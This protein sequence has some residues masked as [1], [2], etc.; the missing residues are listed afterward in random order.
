MDGAPL[1]GAFLIVRTGG[2]VDFAWL[3]ATTGKDG[4]YRL[5]AIPAGSCHVAVQVTR[6][7][8]FVVEVEAATLAPGENRIDVH[9]GEGDRTAE[10]AGRAYSKTT[11][12]PASGRALPEIRLSTLVESAPG[13]WTVGPDA[14]VAY[15]DKEGAFRLPGLRAARYWVRSIHS[16][17]TEPEFEVDLR[18]GEKRTDLEIALPD[19]PPREASKPSVSYLVGTLTDSDGR[20]MSGATVHATAATPGRGSSGS[21]TDGSGRFRIARLDPGPYRLRIQFSGVDGFTSEVAD[22]TVVAGTNS[23]DLH[24]DDAATAVLSGRV[25]ARSSGKSLGHP[26]VRLGLRLLLADG[27]DRDVGMALPTS[28]G[29]FTIRYV[30]PGRLRLVAD[31]RAPGLAQR[32]IELEVTAGARM[33][34]LEVALDDAATGTVVLVVKDG[35]GRPVQ[36]V[37]IVCSRDGGSE[38]APIGGVSA[39]GV[40][41]IY[42]EPGA[43]DVML[44]TRDSID[45][46]TVE[47]RP[48]ETTRAEFTM[49]RPTGLEWSPT[50]PAARREPSVSWLAGTLTDASG[51]P[52]VGAIV[53][54]HAAVDPESY[55]QASTNGRGSF[56]IEGLRPG[57]W[58]IHVQILGAQGFDTEVA[59][60]ALVAG[61]NP[62]DLR[63]G[64]ATTSDVTGR[65]FVRATGR[66][67]SYPELH[68]IAFLVVPGAKPRYVATAQAG[69]DGRFTFHSLPLGRLQ[70]VAW[71]MK[72]DLRKAAF[73]LQ[74][75]A[76]DKPPNVEIALDAMVTGKAVFT[77]KDEDGRPVQNVVIESLRDGEREQGSVTAT[78]TGP[79]SGIYE[80][81]FE[82][83]THAV[84]VSSLDRA[85]V[86]A[87]TLE[88]RKDE[89]TAV[90]VVLHRAK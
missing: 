68:L 36:E 48:G 51:A 14:G 21:P 83:G 35:E 61:A 64:G 52:I 44:Q 45:S 26:Q 37:T 46:G 40:Y 62:L 24:L 33:E 42:L 85:L 47:V 34:K 59:E 75:A 39:T 74:I 78:N 65:V 19:P 67:L 55:R 90:E 11:G 16:G 29:R 57:T 80:T 79:S 38:R 10:V 23:L 81:F 77:V 71:P 58:R 73:D 28:D 3:R 25:F 8:R 32:A 60:A 22:T 41:E 27:T 70:I 30:R 20:P 13:A 66:A 49:H 6:G 82:V 4:S 54:A 43:H 17:I 84:T 56:R 7:G 88:I 31:V 89:T 9:L 63:L 53:R 2:F 5:T 12:K 18:S 69:A 76:G 50:D 86:G 72:G 15:V 1:A 87:T